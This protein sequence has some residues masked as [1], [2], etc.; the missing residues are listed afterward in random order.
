MHLVFYDNKCRLCSRSAAWI[1]KH[2]RSNKF[3]LIP[4]EGEEANKKLRGSLF[5]LKKENSLIL[6]E[7][8]K[9]VWLR[10]KAVMRILWLLGGKWRWIGWLYRCPCINLF[11]RM[12]AYHRR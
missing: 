4:L 5:S 12:I 11:Y 10:G 7:N 6:L 1:G 9:K 8:G 3:L 2:D